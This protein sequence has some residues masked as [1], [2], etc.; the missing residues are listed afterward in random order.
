MSGEWGERPVEFVA[1]VFGALGGLMMM[2]S[3]CAPAGWAMPL[4]GAGLAGALLAFAAIVLG[5]ARG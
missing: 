5:L 2:L 4:A 3:A 1:A